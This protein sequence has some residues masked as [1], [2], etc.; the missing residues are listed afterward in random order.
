M[1]EWLHRSSQGKTRV[2]WGVGNSGI[3]EC[4]ASVFLPKL[5]ILCSAEIEDV[6]L[7][8]DTMGIGGAPT[9]E[10]TGRRSAKKC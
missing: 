10:E 4:I 1:M 6:D 3:L 7:F 2:Y 5:V 9:F 8:C